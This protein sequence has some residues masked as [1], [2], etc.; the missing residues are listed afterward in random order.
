M[1]GK[2]EIKRRKEQERT[3]W[4]NSIIDSM[5]MNLSK[6]WE[7]MD[8]TGTWCAIVHKITKSLTRLSD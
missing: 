4:L 3:R 6:F 5:N 8:D 1:L 2:V 7:I